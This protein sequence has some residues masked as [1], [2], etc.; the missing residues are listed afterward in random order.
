MFEYLFIFCLFIIL[1][2]N[3]LQ[4]IKM[5]KIIFITLF[6]ML[7]C[8]SGFTQHY[9][10]HPEIPLD[11]SYNT[12]N[13]IKKN[14]KK[15]PFISLPVFSEKNDIEYHYDVV[16]DQFDRRELHLDIFKPKK[17][18]NKMPVVL[19]IHGGGWRSGDKNMNHYM[20]NLFAG[21][22]FAAVSVEYRLSLESKYPEGLKDIATAIRW[23]KA[24]AARYGFDKKRVILLGCSS[25]GQMVSLSGSINKKKS[26]YRSNKYDKYTDDVFAV[27][28]FDGVLAF[29]HPDSSEGKDTPGKPSAATAWLGSS[30]ND[31]PELWYEASALTHVN[32]K[33]AK[34]LYINSIQPRFSAGQKDMMKRLDKYGIINEEY[35]IKDAPHSFWLFSPWVEKAVDHSVRFLN[36]V[37]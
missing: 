34:F 9:K 15:Y 24:N 22:G 6:F 17:N 11:S 5:N 36:K 28:D 19:L 29:I 35:M 2:L 26:P 16:Y 4:I 12:S 8:T 37:L 27:I 10:M 31:K 32:K 25:G 33:S 14:I 30:F 20:A 18:I 1:T 23:T 13:E 21:K 7:L 3:Y